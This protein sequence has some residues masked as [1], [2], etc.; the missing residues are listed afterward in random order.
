MDIDIHVSMVPRQPWRHRNTA[1]PVAARRCRYTR[2]YM[3][4]RIGKPASTS[5]PATPAS[6]T[7]YRT[8]KDGTL[9][10]KKSFWI[11]E[12]VAHDF[13]VWCVVN[14]R[15]PNDVIAGLLR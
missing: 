12:K 7:T 4:K 1:P 15:E 9:M 6:G 8:K 14:R 3:S 5:T 2:R 11:E 10:Q 13:E